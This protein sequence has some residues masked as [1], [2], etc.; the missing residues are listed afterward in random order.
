MLT[1]ALSPRRQR[2]H[3][4]TM[5]DIKC[6]AVTLAS[7]ETFK[8]WMADKEEAIA[9]REEN[10]SQ[11]K[12]ATCNQ[13]FDLTKKAVDVEESMAKAKALEAE[14]NLMAEERGIM[15]IDTPNL[16]LYL[17]YLYLYFSTTYKGT[18]LLGYI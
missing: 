1:R 18:N 5:S 17:Y 2:G 15:F 3:K 4:A 14:T 11:E 9:K 12:E 7:S 8:G 10:R 6:D 16:Y 13:F